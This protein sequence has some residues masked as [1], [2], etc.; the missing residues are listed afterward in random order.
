MSGVHLFAQA[1]YSRGK[2]VRGCRSAAG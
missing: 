1:F 2:F